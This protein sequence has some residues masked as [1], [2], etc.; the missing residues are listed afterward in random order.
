MMV[1]ALLQHEVE[2]KVNRMVKKVKGQE[3]KQEVVE[4]VKEVADVAKEVVEVAKEVVEV[5]NEVVE[6]A[7]KVIV[8]VKGVVEIRGMV[9][10][11]EQTTIQSAIL[12]AGVLTDKAI[13]NGALKKN[14]E[15]RGNGG[16]PRAEEA[17]QDPNIMTSTFTLNNHYAITL[18][19]SGADY[20]FVSTTF[21]PLLDIEPSKLDFSYKIE[22]ASGQLIEINKV[23]RGCQLEIEGHTF[24]I[25]LIPF[26]H[27][28][29]DVIV[30]MDWLSR[31]K[32]EIV[33]HEK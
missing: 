33:C 23:I 26:R 12:K 5:A 2:G 31:H 10:A 27:K 11:T 32:A 17:R 28:S 25:D 14:I 8:V 15:K 22:I 30:G 29:F 6:V 18:F 4:V 21:I 9:V 7:K 1:D 24:D 13:R 20:S 16:E 19:D 3:I